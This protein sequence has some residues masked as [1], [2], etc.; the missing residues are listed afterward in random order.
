MINKSERI[1][2]QLANGTTC[3]G[4]YINIKPG[5]RF[6]K[7]NWKVYMVNK[8]CAKEFDHIVCKKDNSNTTN[9]EYFEVK[10]EQS[11]RSITLRQLS[12]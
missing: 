4:L 7:E 3:R 2:E 10:P 6:T 1:D 5:F 12:K 8:I 11:L 9:P